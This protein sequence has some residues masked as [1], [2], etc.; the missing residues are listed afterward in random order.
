MK[1]KNIAFVLTLVFFSALCYS[2]SAFVKGTNLIK[3]GI[4]LGSSI[5]NYSGSTQTPGLSAQFERGVWEFGGPGV[6]SLGGYIGTKSFKYHYSSTYIDYT[7]KW[8]YTIVGVRSAYHYAG[9]KN[10]KAD[11]YGGLM[12]SYNI[13]KYKYQDKSGSTTYSNGL[14]SYGSGAGVT[15][16]L[17]GNYFFS[18]N[19][20]GFGELGYGV[21]YLTLGL[22]LKL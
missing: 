11:L 19:L 22:T 18:G 20:A 7:A 13:L 6:V 17:G 21:S 10:S 12:L 8:N 9:L 5:L 4:G 1:K 3:A 15:A 16:Y 2:Q 14:G